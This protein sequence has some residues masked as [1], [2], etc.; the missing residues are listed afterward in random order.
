MQQFLG[1]GCHAGQRLSPTFLKQ[2]HL[3]P[4]NCSSVDASV[5]TKFLRLFLVSCGMQDG[6]ASAAFVASTAAH[7]MGHI[8]DMGHDDSEFLHSL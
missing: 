4:D 1:C 3:L 2:F 6:G 8:F 7:E 5:I